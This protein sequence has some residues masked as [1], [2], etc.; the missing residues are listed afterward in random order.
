[1]LLKDFAE[2]KVYQNFDD[3]NDEFYEW[4]LF[5]FKEGVRFFNVKKSQIPKLK[6][7]DFR[8]VDVSIL[9]CYLDIDRNSAEELY[10]YM[11]EAK[12]SFIDEKYFSHDC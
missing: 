12:V 11:F 1:M 10:P 3:P 6:R 9:M 5:V 8:I 7:S 2:P 4:K